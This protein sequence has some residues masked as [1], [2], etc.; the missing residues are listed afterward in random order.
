MMIKLECSTSNLDDRVINLH[1]SVIE[2][3]NLN[4]YISDK[5]KALK[6][7]QD[8]KA[9]ITSIF[10][11]YKTAH[12]D[13]SKESITLLYSTAKTDQSF[14]AFQ[15]LADWLFFSETLFPEHL[16]HASGEYYQTVA[17]L[18]YYSCFMLIQK[19]WLLFEELSNNYPYLVSGTKSVLRF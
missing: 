1:N 4:D 13:H 19:K 7:H 15:N 8:T 5:I 14:A 11:K 16:R 12:F 6:C 10:T 17:R 2:V 9:Y 3:I 18:S